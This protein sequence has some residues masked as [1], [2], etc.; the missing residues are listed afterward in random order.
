MADLDFLEK[1]I[2][3]TLSICSKF[4][5]NEIEYVY[6]ETKSFDKT[7]LCLKL[8]ASGISLNNAILQVIK[9]EKK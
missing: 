7:I 9:N 8:S 1:N 4:T 6:K 2:I 5:F 3:K